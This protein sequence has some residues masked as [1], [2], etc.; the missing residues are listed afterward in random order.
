MPAQAQRALESG[1]RHL[2]G[3]RRSAPAPGRLALGQPLPAAPPPELTPA[4][5][6]GNIGVPMHGGHKMNPSARTSAAN[7][8]GHP[9]P[10]TSQGRGLRPPAWGSPP[11]SPSPPTSGPGHFGDSC[12]CEHVEAPVLSV[13][14]RGQRA[15][16]TGTAESPAL[17]SQL[18]RGQSMGTSAPEV[19]PRKSRAYAAGAP[20]YSS[21]RCH[22]LQAA[23]LWGTVRPWL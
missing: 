22:R 6:A 13:P 14:R 10:Q 18:P 4:S 23:G 5:R 15:G 16:H 8:Q 7:S 12:M 9:N 2:L 21:L 1:Q 20:P 11:P 3:K 19:R 17:G